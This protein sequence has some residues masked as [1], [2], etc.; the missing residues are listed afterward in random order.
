MIPFQT[1]SVIQVFTF[2]FDGMHLVPI[3]PKR[4]VERRGATNDSVKND[5]NFE[6]IFMRKFSLLMVKVSDI[7]NSMT[8]DVTNSLRVMIRINGMNTENIGNVV[9]MILAFHPLHLIQVQIWLILKQYLTFK[10]LNL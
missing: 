8:M 10:I 9:F 2:E 1:R 3:P 5:L 4:L 6:I 7:A